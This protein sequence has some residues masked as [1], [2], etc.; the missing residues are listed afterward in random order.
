MPVR[1]RWPQEEGR[2]VTCIC[3]VGQLISRGLASDV[4]S[5]PRAV[6]LCPG[7]VPDQA[8]R[9]FQALRSP[10][11]LMKLRRSNANSGIYINNTQKNF[12]VDDIT[13]MDTGSNSTLHFE[14]NIS[15]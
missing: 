14:S 1:S 5:K 8:A 13:D 11:P 12:T 9:W 7:I 6:D 3:M 10:R 4:A 2:C 15:K